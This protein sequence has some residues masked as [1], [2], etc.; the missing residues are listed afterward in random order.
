MPR[1]TAQPGPPR[2]TQV[3]LKSL[4]GFA[5]ETKRISEAQRKENLEQKIGPPRDAQ[6][7]IGSLGSSDFHVL[8]RLYKEQKVFTRHRY[9][10]IQSKTKAN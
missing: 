7:I 6:V 1:P 3:I 9:S 4:K 10:C 2:G 5:Q 8:M